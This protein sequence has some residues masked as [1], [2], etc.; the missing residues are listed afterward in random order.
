MR[1]TI[2]ATLVTFIVLST[3][4]IKSVHEITEAQKERI[5]LTDK[6]CGKLEERITTL[7]INSSK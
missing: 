4:Y 3:L 2:I 7:E 5:S 6:H 1:T